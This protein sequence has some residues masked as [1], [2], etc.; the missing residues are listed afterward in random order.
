M[1][2]EHD[3]WRGMVAVTGG[4]G[5]IGRHVIAALLKRG[6]WVRA[7][8]RDETRLRRA[9]ADIGVQA[10]GCCVKL[11]FTPGDLCDGDACARLLREADAVV[12]VAGL[13]K[14]ADA[15]AFMRV[16]TEATAALAAQAAQVGTARFVHVSSL[17]A[18]EPQLSTYARS[19][20]SGE[21]AVLSALGRRAVVV[22]PPAVYGPG[23]E[24][25]FALVKQLTRRHGFVPGRRDQ[26]LSLIHVRDLAAGI[27]TL[28]E[29]QAGA[30][31]EGAVLEIDDGR[32]GGY[33]W[34]DMAAQAARTLGRDVRLHLLP[35][36]VVKGAAALADGVSRL[37]GRA[38][39]LSREK[40]GEL[41]HP[42]WVA[43][44]PKV[45]EHTDWA[46]RLKFA[47]GLRD[48][49]AYWRQRGRIADGVM[50]ASAGAKK[51]S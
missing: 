19:K 33:T 11:D 21:E 44:S 2:H 47:E 3:R 20:R 8:T 28:L 43:R 18:R 40:V 41:Y 5:F 23:D 6:W 50:Q 1:T 26:H 15:Q 25:T 22:R 45:Q 49:L 9:L 4:T 36:P 31:V 42:D 37:T 34:A 32:A 24:A 17:A 7:F 30:D 51:E 10:D 12:H 27:A 35:R 48:T 14:A 38:F 46:P 29:P 13:V 39:M 16:N